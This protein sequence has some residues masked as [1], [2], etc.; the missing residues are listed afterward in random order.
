MVEEKDSTCRR[1]SGQSRIAPSPRSRPR[2]LWHLQTRTIREFV[3][4]ACVVSVLWCVR[5]RTEQDEPG[6]GGEDEE[7]HASG[8]RAALDVFKWPAA[9][10]LPMSPPLVPP[11][12]LIRL[13]IGL[14]LDAPVTTPLAGLLLALD[15]ESREVLLV[16][17]H[18]DGQEVVNKSDKGCV[19]VCCC[20][21]VWR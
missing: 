8:A 20:S 14:L 10:P 11:V 2:C 19:R 7:A 6:R 21:I 9:G 3:P 12:H 18:G 4:A 13:V 5:V 15:I 16:G 17:V 1:R